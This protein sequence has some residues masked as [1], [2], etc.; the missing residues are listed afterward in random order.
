[1]NGKNLSSCSE[2]IKPRTP[3]L[4][5]KIERSHHIDEEEFYWMLKGIIIDSSKLFNEKLKEW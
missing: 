3:R 1:M 4:N 2:Y 5:G